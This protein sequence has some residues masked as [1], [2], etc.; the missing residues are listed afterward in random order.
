MT[1]ARLHVDEERS[2]ISRDLHDSVGGE[3]AALAWRMHHISLGSDATR[4]DGNT[5]AAIEAEMRRL[6]ERIRVAL[7][8]L[9]HVV[10]D[11][12]QEQRTWGEMLAKL[13]ELCQDMCQGR[14]LA[15]DADGELD[16]LLLERVIDDVH[17]IVVELVRNAATHANPRRIEVRIAVQDGVNMIVADDGAGLR[18]GD[19]THRTGGLVNVR[20]RVERLGGEIDIQTVTRGTR[21]AI[22]LPPV[23]VEIG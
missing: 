4:E 1:L 15:F 2:R 5:A 13:R 14:Q 3:L 9:R 21:I 11:L 10:L 16:G 22:R 23:G 7:E 12:R 19:T 8:S 17:C 20:A 18:G 6:G